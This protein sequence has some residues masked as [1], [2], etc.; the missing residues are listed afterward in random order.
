VK[1]GVHGSIGVFDAETN[2]LIGAT[3]DRDV[4]RK[5]CDKYGDDLY[6]VETDDTGER[7]VW[8]YPEPGAAA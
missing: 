4:A 8:S 7:I 5:V 6:A 2:N 3:D 1:L